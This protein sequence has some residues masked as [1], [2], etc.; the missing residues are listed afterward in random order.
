MAAAEKG[1]FE[2]S[3]ARFTPTISEAAS[4]ISLK[5]KF[6][7]IHIHPKARLGASLSVP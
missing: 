5:K 6:G 1:G 3:T 4:G 2:S 7:E